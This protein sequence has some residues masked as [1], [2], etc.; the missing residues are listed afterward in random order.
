VAEHIVGPLALALAVKVQVAQ[1]QP[2]EAVVHLRQAHK[3]FTVATTITP[4]TAI[5]ITPILGE[6]V[7]TAGRHQYLAAQSPMP[8][9]AVADGCMEELEALAGV[10]IAVF[11]EQPI[12][13]EAAALATSTPGTL[14]ATITVP[15]GVLVL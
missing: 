15:L 13:A 4:H 14:L 2:E 12:P 1:L 7:V 6:Q 10:E 8:A 9:A 5:S 11:P 3:V